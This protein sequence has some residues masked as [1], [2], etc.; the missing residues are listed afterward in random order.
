M[1]QGPDAW[2]QGEVS[3]MCLD[4]DGC[5]VRRHRA[6]DITIAA[7]TGAGE[8]A[9][10][11]RDAMRHTSAKNAQGCVRGMFSLLTDTMKGLVD[12]GADQSRIEIPLG[13]D[14]FRRTLR[15]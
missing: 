12:A 15:P 3:I 11:Q 5:L 6:S 7:D 1:A 2:A 9:N 8:T 13:G 4:P 10:R 14:G